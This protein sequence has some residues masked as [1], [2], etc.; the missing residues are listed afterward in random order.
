MAIPQDD[1]VAMSRIGAQT[2]SKDTYAT[3]KLA[4][5]APGVPYRTGGRQADVFLQGSYGNDTNI[6]RESDVDVVVCLTTTFTYDDSGLAPFAQAAR[7]AAYSWAT[8]NQPDFDRDV[9]HVLRQRFGADAQPETKAVTIA[10]SHPRRKA[11]VIIALE[12]RKYLNYGG[13]FGELYISGIS[14]RKSD[15]NLVVNYP[16]QHHDNLIAK[17]QR[18]DGR[19]KH[20]IRMFKNLREKLLADGAI[21][22]GSAP[23]YY[24]EG[25]LYNVPDH[26]F[27]GTYAYAVEQILIWLRDCNRQTLQCANQQYPL[28]DG[29]TDVTWEAWRFNAFV[30][31]LINKWVHW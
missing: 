7:A 24:I 4:L 31:A 1:L 28:L 8:Y 12:H 21:V 27:S 11:D 29:N 16:K 6:W 3:V 25:M 23:S 15:G 17:N 26:L 13:L 30:D 10:A 5:E 18:T 9:R 20:I 2:T 22:P 19:F 14:F